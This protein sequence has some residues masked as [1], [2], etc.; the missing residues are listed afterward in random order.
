MGSALVGALAMLAALA[1]LGMLSDG[2]P[3]RAVERVAVSVPEDPGATYQEVGQKAFEAVA[4]VVATRP[5]GQARGTA[6]AYRSDGYLL[7]TADVVAGATSIEVTTAQGTTM[8]ADLVGADAPNDVAVLRVEAV[9]LPTATLVDVSHV[10]LTD[11]VMALSAGDG[12]P[13]ERAMSVGVVSGLRRQLVDDVGTLHG[14]V[15]I[16]VDVDGPAQGSVVVT[17][18]G[19]VV[20]ILTARGLP[21]GYDPTGR[22]DGSDDL[23]EHH[24]TPIDWAKHLADEIVEDGSADH[25]W[26]G[27]EGVDASDSVG[28][29]R[30]GAEVRRVV[31]GSPAQAAELREGDV[32]TTVD[33]EPVR[34]MSDL[35]LA[36]RTH[37][38]GD[39]AVVRYSRG[40]R[41][42]TAT[43]ELAEKP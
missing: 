15:R 36:L 41:E 17:G 23:D 31:E 7:T 16:N 8:E 4:E 3:I 22:V 14:M 24:A 9:D 18:Y 42:A 39:T 20:G 30:A 13:D 26:V 19:A 34:S 21:A 29:A 43:V 32:V 11:T 5:G 37:D 10:R 35:V 27:I 33:D 38:P 6:V 1:G 12:W 25:V 28:G 2:I 40:G